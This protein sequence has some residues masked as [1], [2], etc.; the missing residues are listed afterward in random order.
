MEVF[1]F[2]KRRL[3]FLVKDDHLFEEIN[4]IEYRD[5]KGKFVVFYKK[6]RSGRIFDFT[7]GGVKRYNFDFGDQAGGVLSTDKLVDIDTA[8]LTIFTKRVAEMAA[9]ARKTVKA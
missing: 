6:E 2:V 8:L 4:Y 3:S 9:P 1:H 5:Y 7:E